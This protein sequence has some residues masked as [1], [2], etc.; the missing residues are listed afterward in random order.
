MNFDASV[1]LKV[2]LYFL[3]CTAD[4]SSSTPVSLLRQDC[5]TVTIVGRE[6]INRNSAD[7]VVSVGRSAIS[8]VPCVPA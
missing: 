1:S 5:L 8:R 7:S 6:H 2:I 4:P 3:Y